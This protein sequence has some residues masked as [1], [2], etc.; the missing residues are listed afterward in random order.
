MLILILLYLVQ[1]VTIINIGALFGEKKN[2][3][4]ISMLEAIKSVDQIPVLL[5]KVK[6]EHANV[7][8]SA[9]LKGFGHAKYH[10]S[11][12]RAALAKQLALQ[13]SIFK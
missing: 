6:N 8:S 3:A 9:L 7:G 12:P 2:S 10:H 1:Q 13:V 11:D 5:A 4:V